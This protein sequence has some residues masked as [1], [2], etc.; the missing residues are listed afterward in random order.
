M[1]VEV[2]AW[3]KYSWAAS[4]LLGHG[5][6][7]IGPEDHD[8]GEEK[9]SENRRISGFVQSSESV[10]GSRVPNADGENVPSPVAESGKSVEEERIED[11]A[12][13]NP[14]RG[15]AH[16][17]LPHRGAKDQ[18]DKTQFKTGFPIRELLF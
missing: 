12:L 18:L 3:D 17:S 6:F 9:S 7:D 4:R 14:K 10:Q 1:R 11:G 5:L 16:Q 8:G 15:R 13:K 2:T